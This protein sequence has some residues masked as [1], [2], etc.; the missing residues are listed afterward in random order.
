MWN[1]SVIKTEEKRDTELQQRQTPEDTDELTNKTIHGVPR[2]GFELNKAPLG[3]S[4][5]NGVLEPTDFNGSFMNG[6]FNME[7]VLTGVNS[8]SRN[9][10]KASGKPVG[11]LQ[12]FRRL[13]RFSVPQCIETAL[14]CHKHKH[15]G[16]REWIDWYR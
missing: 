4:R 3:V 8:D 13:L 12:C 14:A 16:S 5:E 6:E 2:S 15:S 10:I 9:D 1:Y 11:G 7:S